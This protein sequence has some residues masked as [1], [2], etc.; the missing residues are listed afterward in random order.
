MRRVWTVVA[1][2]T[3]IGVL[4]SVRR[5]FSLGGAGRGLDEG[6][7]RHATLTAAHVI[8]G[9]LFLLIGPVQFA[10]SIRRRHPVLHRWMGRIFVAAG[11]IVGTTALMMSPQ[12]AIGGSLET[13]ATTAFG[14]WFLFALGKA[15]TAI[16]RR[17]ILRHREWMIRAYST[18]LAVTTIRPIVGFFFATSRLTGLT[19]HDF[20]GIAFWIGF[21]AHAVAAELWISRS[22]RDSGFR[23]LRR[24]RQ[25]S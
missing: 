9:M 13:A 23:S 10:A 24:S 17:E 16:R 3:A 15:Y 22:A 20:F 14:A 8:P 2:L 25:Y 11:V 18:G 1:I 19:P 7:L 4:V 6:F 12:M 21:T 5:L